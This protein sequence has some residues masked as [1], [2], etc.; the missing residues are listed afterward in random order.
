MTGLLDR[1]RNRW[2]RFRE[3]KEIALLRELA[4]YAP[5]S[6]GTPAPLAAIAVAAA[7]ETPGLLLDL[8]Q[9]GPGEPAHD[10]WL[11]WDDLQARP[12]ERAAALGELLCRH[13]SDKA[14]PHNYHVLYAHLLGDPAT[15]DKVLEIGMGSNN[16]D[17]IS[18]MTRAGKPGAS[19]RAFR[20]YL[21]R[22]RI[23]G[24]DI[25]RRILFREDRIDT[26][27]V[28]Q[29]CGA[30]LH[31]LA[32]GVGSGFDLV[33]DDGLHSP[34][35]NLRTLSF[36]LPLLKPG[37]FFV[38][39]DIAAAAEPVWRLVARLL[40]AGFRH[41]LITTPRALVFVVQKT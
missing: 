25:D 11:H 26:H 1:I 23:H 8:A 16:E 5:Y 36:A 13:G 24:A 32:T 14:S 20:D 15:I 27:H 2:R 21:P 17:V 37:G 41:Q 22:A 38:V 7:A 34:H 33:I 3:R 30:S 40:P 19:L 9:S 10:D 31:D 12:G 4:A 6:R 29:T 28:D 35:A 18:N 39:E